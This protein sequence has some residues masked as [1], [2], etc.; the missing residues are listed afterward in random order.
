MDYKRVVLVT[1]GARG[2]GRAVALSLADKETAVIFTHVNP[3]SPGAKETLGLL[4]EKAAVAE[5][6]VWAAENS[7]L[8]NEKIDEI[9]KNYG[10]LDVLVNNAGL[11]ADNLSM[12]MS[13]EEWHKVLETN[14]FGVF[15]CARAAVKFMMKQRAG[16]IVNIGSVVGFTGNPGQAN[17]TAAKAGLIGLT[18]TL[19]LELAGRGITVNAVAPGFIDTDMTKDLPENIKAA[20]MAKIPQNRLGTAE[21]VAQAVAFLASPGAA[22]ITGQTIHVN[23]GLYLG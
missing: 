9:C 3:N 5:A 20:L 14:L 22:Y 7:Q 12:R 6:Q 19:A 17:Y 11:T 15:A 21:D 13:D 2:I 10:R 16:T 23:G 1:G 4:Q 8:A 18:K